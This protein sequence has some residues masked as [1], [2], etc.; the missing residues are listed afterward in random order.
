M[1]LSIQ[2]LLLVADILLVATAS[3][4]AHKWAARNTGT[5]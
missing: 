3:V 2:Y 1:E 5:L 4:Q